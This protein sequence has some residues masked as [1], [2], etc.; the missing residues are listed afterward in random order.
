[1]AVFGLSDRDWKD[2]FTAVRAG[3]NQGVIGNL[4]DPKEAQRF[5]REV[6]DRNAG[7]GQESYL[8]ETA[9]WIDRFLDPGNGSATTRALLRSLRAFLAGEVE[10]DAVA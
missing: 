8:Q 1:V 10:G 6:Y 2:A 7:G 4:L 9:A 5:K 3:I